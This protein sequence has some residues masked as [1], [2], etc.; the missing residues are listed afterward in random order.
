MKTSHLLLGALFLAAPLF[1]QADLIAHVPPGVDP[2][3]DGAGLKWFS[4]TES[5][6]DVRRV[7]GQP[8]ETV[9]FGVDFE[10]WQF[11]ID[12]S[13]G[14]EFSHMLVFRGNKLIA[15]TRNFE[16]ERTVDAWFPES[17]TVTYFYPDVSQFAV[18]VRKLPGGRLLMAMGAKAA[19]DRTGQVVLMRESELRQ[20]YPWLAD[21]F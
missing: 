8:K 2:V 11:Q 21:Q 15:V 9:G 19:G 13:D 4:L 17:Q 20:F 6:D 3:V 14:H 16:E 12:V 7:L 10:S 1:S 5:R 18:R